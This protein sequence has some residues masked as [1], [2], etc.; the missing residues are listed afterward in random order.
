MKVHYQ[1]GRTSKTKQ[2]L[3]WKIFKYYGVIW[4]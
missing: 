3:H 1:S 2:F 4:T